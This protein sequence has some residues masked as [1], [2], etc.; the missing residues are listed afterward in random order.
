MTEQRHEFASDNTAPICP[1][2]KNAFDEANRSSAAAYGED[3]W[4]ERLRDRIRE[5]FECDCAVYL[6]SNGTAANALALAQ[7]CR[8]FH[9]VVCHQYAHI[10]TDECGACEF[11]S[12]GSKLIPVGSEN[13][14]LDLQQVERALVRQ[15]DVHS[16]KPRVVSVTQATELGRIYTRDELRAISSFTRERG[17]LLHMDGARFANAVAALGCRPREITW[18]AGVDILC[19][20]GIKNGLGAG[21]LV[22]FFDKST[23]YEFEYRIKQGGQLSSKM[24]FLASPW[25]GLLEGDVWLKNAAHANSAARDLATALRA[26]GA[27]PV[28][29]VEANSIFVRFDNT[30]VQKLFAL[31]WSFYKF[32]EPDVYRLMCSWNATPE[33]IS[34]FITHLRAA[35]SCAAAVT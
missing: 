6:V 13:G 23:A 17:M 10:N 22:L 27:E 7:V 19:F 8:S 34:E 35:K 20:G 2:A 31:G 28:Y 1:E 5:L 33:S 24:R 16:H 4:T 21:E 29:P 32:I 18:Q 9:A 11:F 25:L 26:E 30:T 3:R 12:G 14:K 15:Q